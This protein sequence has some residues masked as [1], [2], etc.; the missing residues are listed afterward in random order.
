MSETT[1][2][3]ITKE[4]VPPY[5]MEDDNAV[6]RSSLDGGYVTKRALYT[7][8]RKKQLTFK[9]QYLTTK[10]YETLMDFYHT[11]LGN[12]ALDFTYNLTTTFLSKSYHVTFLNPPKESYVGMGLWE[13]TCDF[14]GV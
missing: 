9:W 12:G 6:I 10:E 7:R 8:A 11:T 5:D 3:P 4:P 13:V 1:I 2:F 14:E